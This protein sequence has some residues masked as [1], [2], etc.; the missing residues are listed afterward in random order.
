MFDVRCSIFK[1]RPKG[2]KFKMDPDIGSIIIVLCLIIEAF[3][4]GSEIAFISVNRFKLKHQAESGSVGAKLADKLLDHPERVFATT[5][6]GTNLAVV[7]ST[8]VCTSLLVGHYG[9]K[10]D[11]YTTLIMVPVILLFG[12]II[13]KAVFQEAT[14]TLCPK[15]ARPLKWFMS[16]FYPAVALMSWVTNTFLKTISQHRS[17]KGP[18]LTREELQQWLREGGTESELDEE[19]R[20]MIHN[21]F[22][23]SEMPVEKCMAPLIHTVAVEE[24]STVRHAL[25]VLEDSQYTYSRIPVFQS[26]IFNITGI[27]NTF[28]FLDCKEID[29]PIKPLLRPAYFVPRTKHIDDLLRELQNMGMHM[30]VVVD[31]YGGAIGLVTI[32]DLLE[33]IVGEIEDEFDEI[34]NLYEKISDY[35]Y[36]I[37]ATMEVDA[38]NDELSLNLPVG[39]YET[40]GGLILDQIKRIPKQGEKVDL[41]NLTFRIKEANEKRILFVEVLIKPEKNI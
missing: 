13:P 34:E 21:I 16:L 9:D 12:E 26:R 36:I 6:L 3:F 19:E 25:K 40:L 28:D 39:D 32:E 38:I 37:D 15:I 5:S 7:T 11:L 23:F 24:N 8:A 33:E 41:G 18:L 31:E 4:S 14:D 29:Q 35:R 27:L 10:A 17:D 1:A 22:H 30:A 20:K 2:A